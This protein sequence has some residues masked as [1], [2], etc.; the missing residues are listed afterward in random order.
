MLVG[1]SVS[2]LHLGIAA[3]RMAHHSA[4]I[5]LE[6]REHAIARQRWRALILVVKAKLEAVERAGLVDEE[7]TS[8]AAGKLAAAVDVLGYAAAQTADDNVLQTLQSQPYALIADAL[9]EAPMRNVDLA[10]QLG[11]DEAQIS[12]WLSTLREMG[13]V[14]SHKRGRDKYN[15]LT[16]IGR[17]AVEKGIEDDQRMALGAA[18]VCT[19]DAYRPYNLNDITPPDDIESG[20][21]PR[22]M[23]A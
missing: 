23:T 8:F 22:L 12:K 15:A 20:E 6:P 1:D 14:T 9:S 21:I 5:S 16:P 7:S 3:L 2:G 4:P 13:A 11:K 10:V 18:N 17:L 19:M